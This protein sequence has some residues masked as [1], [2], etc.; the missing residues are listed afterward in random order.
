MEKERLRR[1]AQE[2]IRQGRLPAQVPLRTWGGPGTGFP[3][4]LCD[5]PILRGEIE[6]ELEFG[7][8]PNSISLRFHAP[9]HA[10]WELER[11][12]LPE[13]PG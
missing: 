9:C 8:T 2:R 4:G 6:F 1:E 12:S 3:C 7:D 10:A 13:E 5:L 11:R